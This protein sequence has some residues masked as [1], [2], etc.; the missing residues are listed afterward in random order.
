[1]A[2]KKT[3]KR[4]AKTAA[5][6]SLPKASEE[7]EETMQSMNSPEDRADVETAPVAVE[8]ASPAAYQGHD[9]RPG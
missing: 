6:K 1:M 7:L 2:E 3:V 4:V 9:R 5:K 8:E